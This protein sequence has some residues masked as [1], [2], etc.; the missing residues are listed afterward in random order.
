MHFKCHRER[1]INIQN[2]TEVEFKRISSTFSTG[3]KA[4]AGSQT[5][6]MW[7]N[8]IGTYLSG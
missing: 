2:S 6:L 5:T 3:N 4:G 8:I 7:K 1:K